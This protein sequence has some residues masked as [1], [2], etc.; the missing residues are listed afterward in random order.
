MSYKPNVYLT[1][2]VFTPEEIGSNEK[3][4]QDVRD[5]IKSIWKKLNSLS[6]LKYFKGRFPKE[7]EIKAAIKDFNPNIIGCHLSHP[8]SSDMLKKMTFSQ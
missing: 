6:T 4:S 1:S 2:N 7:A 3:I 5:K 8:I